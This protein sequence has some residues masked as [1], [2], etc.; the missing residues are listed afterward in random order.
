MYKRQPEYALKMIEKGF[1]LVTV[2][3]DHRS[4]SMGAKLIIDK[5]K[6]STDKG[7]TKSY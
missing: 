5:I 2:G 6:G 4:I 3:S 7:S 1:N